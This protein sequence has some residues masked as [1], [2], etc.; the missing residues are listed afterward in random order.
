M[1]ESTASAIEALTDIVL[2]ITIYAAVVT[3]IYAIG[4]TRTR[5]E[6]MGRA[7]ALWLCAVASVVLV[8]WM[9]VA[10]IIRFALLV[11]YG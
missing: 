7:I 11:G 6:A 10:I 9:I 2:Y 8:V 3:T 1:I 4:E 5:S